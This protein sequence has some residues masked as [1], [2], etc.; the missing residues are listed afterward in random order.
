[1][2][3][4]CAASIVFCLERVRDS[5][6][7]GMDH[8]IRFIRLS[9]AAN[10]DSDFCYFFLLCGPGKSWNSIIYAKRDFRKETFLL[11]MDILHMDY[12]FL[13]FSGIFYHNPI[14]A[15]QGSWYI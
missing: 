12:E 6:D 14:Y 15:F 3:G 11:K 4:K 10:H 2:Y 5:I 9:C 8:R 1:M 7:G 13:F